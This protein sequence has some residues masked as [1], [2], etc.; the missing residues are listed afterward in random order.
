MQHKARLSDVEES[1][2]RPPNRRGQTG[3]RGPLRPSA[4]S[5]RGVLSWEARL[6]HILGCRR[7]YDRLTIDY[8]AFRGFC[9]EFWKVKAQQG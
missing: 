5:Y 6:A 8:L 3:S 4:R 1:A 7:C 9:R 2:S